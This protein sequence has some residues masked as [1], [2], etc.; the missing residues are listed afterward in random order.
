MRRLGLFLFLAVTVLFPPAL[1]FAA[2]LPSND[3]SGNGVASQSPLVGTW[4]CIDH[5]FH[6]YT[7]YFWSFGEDSRFAYYVAGFEPPQG[8]GSIDSSV[9][10]NFVQGRF[11]V[12][13]STIECYDIKAD[14][15]FAWG[16]KWKYFPDRDPALL[17]G[18]LL[19]TPLLQSESADDFSLDFELG[20]D[21]ILRLEIDRSDFPDQ[22]GMNFEYVGTAAT[23]EPA[24][25]ASLAELASKL[26]GM[27]Y[28]T[29]ENVNELRVGAACIFAESEKQSIP[30]RW[31][32]LI[33]DESLISVSSDI[34]K[35]TSGFNAMPGGDSAY[36]K[37]NFIAVAP[38][39]CVITLR[40]G[41]YGET[42]W[43]GSFAVEHVFHIMIM[44]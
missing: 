24:N 13:G 40:Y 10:E 32:Y 20:S 25:I 2:D 17:S 11:R 23:A 29:E 27:A 26:T 28:L 43:D 38:G 34:V 16:D 44:E 4:Y 1:A 31:R 8:G 35:D 22:Y 36:R 12:N 41:E 42:D 7:E 14:S 6:G 15:Y 19:A 39:E 21:R 30:Y 18:M 33:S 3:T 9:S 37:I 5:G